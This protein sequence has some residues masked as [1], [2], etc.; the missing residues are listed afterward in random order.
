MNKRYLELSWL[1][2]ANLCA[3]NGLVYIFNANQFILFPSLLISVLVTA[4]LSLGILAYIKLNSKVLIISIA[5]F[6][7]FLCVFIFTFFTTLSE[8]GLNTLGST[9][10]IALSKAAII[11]LM[12]AMIMAIGWIP[13]SLLNYFWI[14]TIY[15]KSI[16]KI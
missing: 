4:L 3:A 2:L 12:G 10:N 9:L 16:Q 1:Y 8:V 6:F 5:L 7:G 14:K 15:S 13:L 11:G